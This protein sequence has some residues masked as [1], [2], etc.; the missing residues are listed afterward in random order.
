MPRNYLQSQ[1]SPQPFLFAFFF[2][3]NFLTKNPTASAKQMYVKISCIMIKYQFQYSSFG[4]KK[5]S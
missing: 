3:K 1:W 5:N 4:Y 2:Q